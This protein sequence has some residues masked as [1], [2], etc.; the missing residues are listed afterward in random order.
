MDR[1]S[2][3]PPAP[4][5]PPTPPVR[6]WIVIVTPNAPVAVGADTLPVL[7][8]HL[9]LHSRNAAHLLAGA[10]VIDR[11]ALVSGD[12]TAGVS[13]SHCVSLVSR[14]SGRRW[15]AHAF[16]VPGCLDP[17][18][19]VHPD[20]SAFFAMI[21]TRGSRRLVYRSPDGRRTWEPQPTDFGRRH[22]HPT[23]VVD[24]TVG[25]RH[26]S[27]YVVSRQDVRRADGLARSHAYVARSSVSEPVLGNAGG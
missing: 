6:S 2:A 27:V 13:R 11:P 18:V 9:A 4:R 20:G 21:S 10:T 15:A 23:L 26:G 19:A 1:A 16:P 12:D 14:D 24:T 17:W 8:P 25:P 3:P 5:G 7:E 22:D